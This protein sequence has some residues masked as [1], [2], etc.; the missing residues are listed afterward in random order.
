MSLFVVCR[1]R[2]FTGAAPGARALRSSPGG[3]R[4]PAAAASRDFDTRIEQA[5]T[6][7]AHAPAAL[8]AGLAPTG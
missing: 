3:G 2:D 8:L 1:G 5:W 4:T 6:P 7:H